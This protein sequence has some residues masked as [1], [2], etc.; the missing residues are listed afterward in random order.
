ML[1]KLT[2]KINDWP[3]VWCCFSNI[4]APK[5][6]SKMFQCSKQTFGCQVSNET[7]PN[8]GETMMQFV[9][10]H[11]KRLHHGVCL[12]FSKNCIMVIAWFLFKS[13]AFMVGVCLIWDLTYKGPFWALKHFWGIF[14]GCDI[15]K[16]TSNFWSIN[17]FQC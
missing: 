5:Y 6:P 8:H 13:E 14:T 10:K 15:W 16:T 12:F 4:A 2:L 9:L 11:F 3:K 17:N 7:D 1:T